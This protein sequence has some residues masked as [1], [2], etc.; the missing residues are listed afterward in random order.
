[1]TRWAQCLCL[2]TPHSALSSTTHC[3]SLSQPSPNSSPAAGTSFHGNGLFGQLWDDRLC[4][5]IKDGAGEHHTV[6]GCI[7]SGRRPGYA[8]A[9]QQAALKALES[10]S[11]QSRSPI[12]ASCL[13]P[14]EAK[15]TRNPTPSIPCGTTELR[16]F[17]NILEQLSR[18]KH[19]VKCQM[20]HR[21][22]SSPPPHKVSIIN[23]HGLQRKE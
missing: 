11:C 23:T 7:Q 22:E 1:M 14:G 16:I 9:F 19:R 12:Q 17:R 5:S 8:A 15:H 3:L 21:T 13:K 2:S 6:V 10:S 18:D 4:R 20:C